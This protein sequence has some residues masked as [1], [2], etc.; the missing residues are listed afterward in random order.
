MEGFLPFSRAT[1]MLDVVALAMFA[2]IPVMLWAIYLVKYRKNYQLHKRVQLWLGGVLFV[3]VLLFELDIRIN[4]WRQHATVSPHYD[5]ML[6]PILYIHLFFAISTSLL[7]IYTIIAAW[8]KFPKP[9]SP[10]GYSRIHKPVAKTAAVFMCM[11]AITG[12]T[13]YYM[14]FVAGPQDVATPPA[15]TAAG[16][17]TDASD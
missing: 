16:Q 12:W 15:A 3:T 8:R 11:T 13:F 9:A 4:G 2:V 6:F 5:G 17:M 1:I 10:N 7:W 14:A